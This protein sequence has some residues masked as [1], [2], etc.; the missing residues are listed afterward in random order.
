MFCACMHSLY[1]LFVIAWLVKKSVLAS[2]D[3]LFFE[4]KSVLASLH[5]QERWNF[6][7]S[8]CKWYIDVE[9]VTHGSF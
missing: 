2:L 8:L 6:L 7:F 1:I 5:V 9:L 3:V 4:R